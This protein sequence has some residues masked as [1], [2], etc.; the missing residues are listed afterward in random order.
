MQ[1]LCLLLSRLPSPVSCPLFPELKSNLLLSIQGKNFTTILWPLHIYTLGKWAWV[2]PWT[3]RAQRG[4]REM[5]KCFTRY[6]FYLSILLA[7]LLPWLRWQYDFI[8]FLSLSKGIV[9]VVVVSLFHY[10]YML[11]VYIIIFLFC[12]FHFWDMSTVKSILRH[13]RISG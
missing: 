8:I 7:C 3:Q 9:V 4:K 13:A 1:D 11:V 6:P 5:V 2:W 10:L 12:C